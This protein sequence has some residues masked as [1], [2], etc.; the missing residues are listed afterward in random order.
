MATDSRA[1][2]SFLTPGCNLRAGV[3]LVAYVAEGACIRNVAK[4]SCI[5]DASWKR[6]AF[7]ESFRTTAAME[8]RCGVL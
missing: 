8:G 5:R 2:S 3:D 1:T 4:G 6:A 7:T